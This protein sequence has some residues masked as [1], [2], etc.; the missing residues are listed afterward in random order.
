[1]TSTALEAYKVTNPKKIEE[2]L[3]SATIKSTLINLTSKAFGYLKYLAIAIFIG[4]N[5]K[6]DDYFI[7]SS[8]L[9]I[10]LI[11]G[12]AFDSVGIPNLVQAR[13]SSEKNLK[14]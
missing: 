6:T 4:F 12:D 7:A 8:L 1:M 11:F 2:S 9:G 13:R 5:A 3:P 14:N 10:F